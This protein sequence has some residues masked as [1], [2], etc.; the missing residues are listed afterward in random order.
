[1]HPFLRSAWKILSAN[2]CDSDN[3]NR[4]VY[5]VFTPAPRRCFGDAH[6]SCAPSPAAY[7]IVPNIF[8]MILCDVHYAE[9]IIIL[10]IDP[11]RL[12]LPDAHYPFRS[13]KV[14][15]CDAS[16][17]ELRVVQHIHWAN[18]PAPPAKRGGELLRGQKLHVVVLRSP[19]ILI[20]F[21]EQLAMNR[22]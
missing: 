13:G 20:V 14:V 19:I 6:V 18:P 9:A 21:S 4:K 16:D 15:W 5:V 10:S 8:E 7:I 3:D 12:I 11:D 1:M 22:Y 2:P 17:R